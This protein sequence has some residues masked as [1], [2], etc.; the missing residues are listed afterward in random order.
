MRGYW[1]FQRKITIATGIMD[2]DKIFS[3]ESYF[4]EKSI[5]GKYVF[6]EVSDTGCGMDENTRKRLFDPFFTTKF[7]GRGLGL[8][9]VFGIVKGHK[10]AV[11]VDSE[12]SKGTRIKVIFP[13]SSTKHI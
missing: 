5:A 12:L 7:T 11:F 10:G 9:A 2:S 8:A 6:F 1:R 4:E 13:A 3:E